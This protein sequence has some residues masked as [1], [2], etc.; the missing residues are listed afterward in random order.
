MDDWE[1]DAESGL[2]RRVLAK[3]KIIANAVRWVL[4]LSQLPMLMEF[5]RYKKGK[6]W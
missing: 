4:R 6:S 5:A 1:Y 2:K 3:P